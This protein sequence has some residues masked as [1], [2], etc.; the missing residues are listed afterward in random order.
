MSVRS[1]VEEKLRAKG[2]KIAVVG[3]GMSC[4][5]LW[6]CFVFVPYNITPLGALP[7]SG[8]VP[9]GG[10]SGKLF[11]DGE[12]TAETPLFGLA[13]FDAGNTDNPN[14]V[15]LNLTNAFWCFCDFIFWSKD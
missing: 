13:W 9:C 6:Y 3:L 2:I 15:R 4:L 12:A 11:I 1:V 5:G 7:L 8:A 10:N 14:V